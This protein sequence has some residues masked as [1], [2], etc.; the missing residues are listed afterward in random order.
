MRSLN[1]VLYLNQVSANFSLWLVFY[2]PKFFCVCVVLALE[3]RALEITRQALY[4]C[5][6]ELRIVFTVLRG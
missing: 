1:K 6:P 5:I 2:I 4:H 3:P